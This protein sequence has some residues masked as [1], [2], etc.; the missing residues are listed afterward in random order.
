MDWDNEVFNSTELNRWM[1]EEI[2]KH[3]GPMSGTDNLFC[4]DGYFWNGSSDG[5][6]PSMYHYVNFFI[7]QAYNSTAW[8]SD[9]DSRFRQYSSFWLSG[10]DPDGTMT[11]EEK[12]RHM[13]K[14]FIV[15]ENFE[16]L[17]NA[18]GSS[19]T[20]LDGSKTVSSLGMAKW[21]PRYNG[22]FMQKGGAGTYHMERDYYHASGEY[23]WHR[24]MI[25]IMNP[26]GTQLDND[27]N[28]Y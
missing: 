21:K 1:F 13:A 26:A 4:I 15:T 24:Q 5:L 9:L 8:V 11:E 19:W 6:E 3:M 23:Y 12:Y 14:K 25:Q 10:V 28:R 16:K 18:G 2:G 20:D 7:S 17:S 27:D 22:E